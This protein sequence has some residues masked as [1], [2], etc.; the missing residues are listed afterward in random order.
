MDHD[1]I[2]L[3]APQARALVD[4]G[5]ALLLDTRSPDDFARAD[6]RLPGSLRVTPEQVLSGG[7][8]R[9]GM[10]VIAYCT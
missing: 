7:R 1:N 9:P 8:W 6:S 2:K 10:S 5:R 3:T 4:Q